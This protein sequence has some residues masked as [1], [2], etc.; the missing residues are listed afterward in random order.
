MVRPTLRFAGLTDEWGGPGCPE[1]VCGSLVEDLTLTDR[2]NG[3]QTAVGE[4]SILVQFSFHPSASV[5]Q[6]PYNG[7]GV[8]GH[9]R[10][11]VCILK[12]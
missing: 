8:A 1:L 12:Q 4:G 7:V 2:E 3:C 10:L 11:S 9:A 5:E 6:S